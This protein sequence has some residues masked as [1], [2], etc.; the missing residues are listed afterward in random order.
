MPRWIDISVAL[1]PGLLHWPGEPG[2]QRQELKPLPGRTS[3]FTMG[4]HS[5]THVDAPSHFLDGAIGID[6]APLDALNGPAVVVEHGSE[7]AIAADDVQRWMVARGGR[8]LLKTANSRRDWSN[9]PFDDSHVGLT[10]EA[11]RS[12]ARQGV[13]LVGIDYLSIAA[14]GHSE[15]VHRILLEAGIWILEGLD[16]ASVMP[17]EHEL[18][19]LPLRITGGDGA[20]ARTVLRA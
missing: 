16:L 19:C 14:P 15:E 10:P 3:V 5:G 4:S 7:E 9:Q 8:L 18:C 2:F 12:L 1:T 11:A 13:A 6:E 17:G 20:P